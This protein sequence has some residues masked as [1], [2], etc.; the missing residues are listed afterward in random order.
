MT[1][2]KLNGITGEL[3]DAKKLRTTL[4]AKRGTFD[5]KA[6]VL[7]LY[8]S[9]D[10]AGDA[11]MKAKLTRATIDTKENIITS[12]EP[13]MV[14]MEAGTI[15]ANQMTARQKAKEYTF[16][17]KVRTHL[18]AREGKAEPAG[19]SSQDRCDDRRV[20]CAGRY[21]VEQARRERQY[22][23][24]GVHGHGQRFARRRVDDDA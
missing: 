3:I 8:D 18:N 20:K 5:N 1:V 9:I 13:V 10:V 2:I 6:N 22:Q 19:R 4:A 7:E 17:D 12:R 21:H 24:G 11:G 15:S 16:V 23:D 14:M